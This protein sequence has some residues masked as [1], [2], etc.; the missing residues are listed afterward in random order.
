MR[1]IGEY[2]QDKRIK[3]KKG[4]QKKFLL[5]VKLESGMTWKKLADKV[6]LSEHTLR[7]DWQ[8]ERTTIP[9]GIGELLAKEYLPEEWNNILSSSSIKILPLKWGQILSGEKNKKE[10]NAATNS[11]DTAEFL[12]VV[13]G[14]GHLERKTLTITGN[15]NEKAHY[16]YLQKK[17]KE[18]FGLDSKIFKI[19][20]I[21]AIRLKVYSTDLIKRLLENKLVL[22]NKIKN[23]ASFPK[24]IFKNENFMFGALRGL[25]DTDGGIYFKQ[26]KY[27]RAFIEFQTSSPYIREDILSILN[28]CGFNP[29]K[30]STHSGYLNRKPGQNIRIQNQDEVFR[31]FKTV[32]CCH[33]VCSQQFTC[34]FCKIIAYNRTGYSNYLVRIK[35]CKGDKD[36]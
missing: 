1:K 29:S 12:G 32:E 31:F 15:S 26:K 9:Y 4:N 25:F 6:N 27:R 19:K 28:K 16:L 13:L 36:D 5:K 21:N 22:G 10:I 35:G 3:F 30:S 17:I 34:H 33:F 8:N 24:W 2:I 23:K 14:D 11:E 18:L 7:V 20:G